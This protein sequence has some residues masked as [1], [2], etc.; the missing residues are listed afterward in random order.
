MAPRPIPRRA[1]YRYFHR[2]TTRWMD[3]DVYGHV[4]NATYYSY[5]D[6]AINH[7]LITRGGLDIERDAVVGFIASSRC[8]FFAPLAYPSVAEV[9]VRADRIG[10]SSLEYG[11]ALFAEGEEVAR[12]AG[13]MVHVFVDRTTSKA[14]AI[15]PALRK[16]LEE[17][18]RA[19]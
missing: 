13:A 18:A 8:E 2:V 4:N 12:A 16:A 10:K 9:G 15:P 11:V 5:F 19:G 6:T 17:I 7:Y 3:N 1:D 14:V